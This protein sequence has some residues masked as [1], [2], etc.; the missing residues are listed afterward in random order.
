[1]AKYLSIHLEI[2]I[3]PSIIYGGY[4]LANDEPD[5]YSTFEIIDSEACVFKNIIQQHN[6]KVFLRYYFEEE[7]EMFDEVVCVAFV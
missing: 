3:A 5:H 4:L 2:S 1:M 7:N 6:G